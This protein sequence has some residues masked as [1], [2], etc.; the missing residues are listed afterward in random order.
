MERLGTLNAYR[1]QHDDN[2]VIPL[3]CAIYHGW[4]DNDKPTE[5]AD[6]PGSSNVLR[7]LSG[8][9]WNQCGAARGDTPKAPGRKCSCFKLCEATLIKPGD[10]ING[11]L[12]KY[13]KDCRRKRLYYDV[14]IMPGGSA[15]QQ[16]RE[17]G[18]PGRREIVRFVERGGGYVGIC[19][20]AFLA[21]AFHAPERSLKL[22]PLG[23]LLGD[24]PKPGFK[25]RW[26]R[27]SGFLRVQLTGEGRRLLWD[28][29]L[30]WKEEDIEAQAGGPGLIVSRYNN[31]PLMMDDRAGEGVK[32]LAT[33]AESVEEGRRRFASTMGA[34]SSTA[35]ASVSSARAGGDPDASVGVKM[36]GTIAI[37]Y[38]RYGAGKGRV[39]LIS[40][41]FEST[42]ASDM[43]LSKGPGDP[44]LARLVQRAVA[45]AG[46]RGGDPG[47]E[48]W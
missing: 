48:R 8:M 2:K 45:L 34:C 10:V 12:G 32:V 26:Q 42:R 11:A 38:S 28:E 4:W 30:S 13:R 16:S 36:P 23:C 33:F 5:T 22:A 27:G 39:V 31:G 40:P 20:G 44:R 41:H 18:A 19:A 15:K 7:L 35:V 24:N 1:Q 3:R 37:A 14:L 17:L 47:K 43:T 21:C 46:G 9:C 25:Q 6:H 29:G